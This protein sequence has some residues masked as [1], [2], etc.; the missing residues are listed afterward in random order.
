MHHLLPEVEKICSLII[1]KKVCCALYLL[2]VGVF[3]RRLM[4]LC[5]FKITSDSCY[6]QLNCCSFHDLIPSILPMQLVYSKYD[7][8]G[9]VLFGTK[10]ESYS[11]Y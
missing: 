8:V 11:N 9:I 10:G 6:N 4:H 3:F 2:F 5:P 1:Q 7:E